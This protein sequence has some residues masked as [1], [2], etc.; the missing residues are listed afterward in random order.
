MFAGE[1][2]G[3]GGGCGVGDGRRMG[4]GCW[5]PAWVGVAEGEQWVGSISEA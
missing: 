3:S 1:G 4:E 5:N 2:G